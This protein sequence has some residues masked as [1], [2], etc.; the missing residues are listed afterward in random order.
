M[1][2]DSAE[3]DV[4]DRD[5]AI[6][7]GLFTVCREWPEG[8]VNPCNAPAEFVLW[9]KLFPREALGPRCYDHAVT[10]THW[11]MPSRVSQWAVIDLRPVRRHVLPPEGSAP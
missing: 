8:E 2:A 5:S 6:V 4:L 3:K 7:A 1:T 10:H 9:G 11:D